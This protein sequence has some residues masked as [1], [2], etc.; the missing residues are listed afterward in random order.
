MRSH[1]ARKSCAV[2]QILSL[3]VTRPQ[4]AGPSG[5]K[6]QR[7]AGRPVPREP[8]RPSPSPPWRSGASGRSALPR[9][10][11]RG[12]RP[13]VSA[14]ATAATRPRR[15]AELLHALGEP[16][17]VDRAGAGVEVEE[18][19]RELR[20][21]GEAA[22]DGDMLDRVGADIF[23]HAADESRPCRSE[24]VSSRPW[25][26]ATALSETAPVAPATWSRPAAR[27]HIDA[28]VDRVDPGRA[29][30]GDDDPGRAEDGE[31]ADDAERG[32]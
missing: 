31:A 8:V 1:L 32:R 26:C 15:R 10:R 7:R 29:G 13:R 25:S 11:C 22:G 4:A 12:P 17:Q 5:R 19:L 18:A 3:R 21:L 24:A 2:T 14:C 27:G 16:A 6:P 23:Q 30:I 20:H 9:Q 28:A